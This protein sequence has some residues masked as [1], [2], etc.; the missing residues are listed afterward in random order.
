MNDKSLLQTETCVQR[1]CNMFRTHLGIPLP[2]SSAMRPCKN[3]YCIEDL[4]RM[5]ACGHREFLC[6]E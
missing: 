1:N 5:Y 3:M 2:T 4:D 6:V